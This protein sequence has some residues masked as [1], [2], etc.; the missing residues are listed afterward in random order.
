MGVYREQQSKFENSSS[1]NLSKNESTNRIFTLASADK[2]LDWA[3][4][5]RAT[6]WCWLFIKS[7]TCQRLGVSV[8]GIHY[9]KILLDALIPGHNAVNH[10]ERFSQVKQFFIELEKQ[11][12][13]STTM[14][15]MNRMRHGWLV[16]KDKLRE[17]KWLPKTE[18]ATQWA[19]NYIRK[20]PYFKT[21]ISFWFQ[22]IDA[23]ERHMAIVA[24]FDENFPVDN[25]DMK[26]AID[27]RSK[28]L[29]K[30]KTAYDKKVK[31]AK[32]P[33]KNQ[34]TVKISMMAKEKLDEIVKAQGGSQQQVIEDMIINY[35][36]WSIK[37]PKF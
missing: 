37:L 20:Q 3:K 27:S 12:S 5:S 36:Y 9:D 34:L 18:P 2:Q 6:F 11:S 30:F 13:Q 24:T 8:H 31:R 22:P 33:G 32:D 4:S 1:Q 23:K 16:V 14:H 21:G 17:I 26:E 19:W 29:N 28:Q 10:Q 35:F 25:S 15:V 7:A